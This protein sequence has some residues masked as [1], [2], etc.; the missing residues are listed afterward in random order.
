MILGQGARP[1]LDRVLVLL[2]RPERVHVPDALS[3]RRLVV[4]IAGHAEEQALV[5]ALAEGR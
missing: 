3:I 1:A 4:L 5:D 2:L